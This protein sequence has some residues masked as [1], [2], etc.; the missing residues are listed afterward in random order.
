[1]SALRA[2]GVSRLFDNDR[3]LL[4]IL[5]RKPT[6]EELRAVH[7]HLRTLQAEDP[8]KPD[9]LILGDGSTIN[10]RAPWQLRDRSR[11]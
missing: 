4:L 9:A 10:L 11:A 8:Q 6:D 7:E 2:I 1:M 3:A 5:D